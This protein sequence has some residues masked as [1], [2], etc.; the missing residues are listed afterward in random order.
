M[1]HHARIAHIVAA[2]VMVS[3][4]LYGRALL[5]QPAPSTGPI[6]QPARS[7]PTQSTSNFSPSPDDQVVVGFS[8]GA[9][10]APVVSGPVW[11]SSQP[12][13]SQAGGHARIQPLQAQKRALA[14]EHTPTSANTASTGSTASRASSLDQST[15]D[16]KAPAALRSTARA[17]PQAPRSQSGARSEASISAR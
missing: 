6:Q 9:A 4:A 1:G 16:G 2:G 17:Q 14:P 7:T 5:A 12:P 15:H 13:P 8:N 3:C 11:G 10:R